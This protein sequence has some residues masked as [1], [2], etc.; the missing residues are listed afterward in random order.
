MRL[1]E[2]AV[3]CGRRDI[4]KSGSE[5]ARAKAAETLADVR[6]AMKIDYFEN[7]NLFK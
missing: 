7:D 3:R 2:S 1:S 4:L 6:R 5:V